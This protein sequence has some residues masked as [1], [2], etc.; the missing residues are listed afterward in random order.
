M[1]FKN[2]SFQA[3]LNFQSLIYC[4]NYSCIAEVIIDTDTFEPV[5]TFQNASN[6]FH[7]TGVA[8]IF[9]VLFGEFHPNTH[10]RKNPI[11]YQQPFY[12]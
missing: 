1:L 11:F 5:N 9:S 8:L 12:L 3:C 2:S 6:Y 4:I 7:T 10:S